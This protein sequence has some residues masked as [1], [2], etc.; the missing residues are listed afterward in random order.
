MI[1]SVAHVV[2][3][4]SQIAGRV[5]FLGGSAYYVDSCA[6]GENRTRIHSGECG[7]NFAESNRSAIELHRQDGA[8]KLLCL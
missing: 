2:L 8:V 4:L 5:Y 3:R 7:G 1:G 6:D